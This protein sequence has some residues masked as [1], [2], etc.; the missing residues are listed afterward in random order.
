M[1]REHDPGHGW[2]SMSEEPAPPAPA[3]KLPSAPS[4]RRQVLARDIELL[5]VRRRKLIMILG[6]MGGLVLVLPLVLIFRSGT[7]S[8]P[9]AAPPPEMVK[10]AA[11]G[12][13][14]PTVPITPAERMKELIE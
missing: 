10:A 9:P 11:P 5:Q 13:P 12:K 3:S 4:T 1:A 14:R 8:P 7:T 6:A 2:H